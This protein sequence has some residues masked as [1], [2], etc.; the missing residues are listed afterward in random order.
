[1]FGASNAFMEDSELTSPTEDQGARQVMATDSE[2]TANETFCCDLGR[3]VWAGYRH[4]H[5]F[6]RQ[7]PPL[8]ADKCTDPELSAFCNHIAECEAVPVRFDT[9]AVRRTRSQQT[10]GEKLPDTTLVTSSSASVR[11]AAESLPQWDASSVV[12]QENAPLIQFRHRRNPNGTWDSICLGC[13]TT[14]GAATDSEQGLHEIEKVHKCDLSIRDHA[15]RLGE[16]LQSEGL[17]KGAV[18]LTTSHDRDVSDE[19]LPLRTRL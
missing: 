9:K 11:H 16:L 3:R 17:P 18:P 2:E 6:G 8:R 13:Y 14:A 12:R 10:T 15:R 19:H 7:S 4:T 1:M 5:P